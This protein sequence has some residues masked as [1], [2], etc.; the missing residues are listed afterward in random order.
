MILSTIICVVCDLIFPIFNK[1][2]FLSYEITIAFGTSGKYL[3][4]Y[5]IILYT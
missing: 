3:S 4:M 2:A 1:Q 5:A